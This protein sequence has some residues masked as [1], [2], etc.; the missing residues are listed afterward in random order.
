MLLEHPSHNDWSARVFV[1]ARC[2]INLQYLSFSLSKRLLNLYFIKFNILIIRGERKLLPVLE[3]VNLR[4]A[5]VDGSL[6]QNKCTREKRPL[7]QLHCPL[8]D[9]SEVSLTLRNQLCPTPPIS[10]C[11]SPPKGS[12]PV[13]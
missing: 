11:P 13:L 8:A 2:C 9:G 6:L 1:V 12:A 4:I 7:L 3:S 5:I 10:D